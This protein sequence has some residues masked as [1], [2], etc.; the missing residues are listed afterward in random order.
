MYISYTDHISSV[1]L[2]SLTFCL[3]LFRYV[4]SVEQDFNVIIL[5]FY[6]RL[7]Q[8]MVKNEKHDL[9]RIASYL[10]ADIVANFQRIP[11]SPRVK[12]HLQNCVYSLLQ[13]LDSHAV[14]FLMRNLPSRMVFQQIYNTYN[15]YYKYTGS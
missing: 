4:T 3:C 10:I 12:F 6:F 8:S 1:Y 13:L 5:F 14:G 2:Y 15:T 7:T 9:S 11:V